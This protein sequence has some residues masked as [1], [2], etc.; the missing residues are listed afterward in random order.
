MTI[1]AFPKSMLL[2]GCGNMAGAMLR[3]WLAG[4][5][6]PGRFVV[7]KPSPDN[8]PG[9][10]AHFGSASAAG[11]PYDTLII[12]V[13]PQMLEP[14][15]GEIRS[16]LAPGALV[17]SIL[18]GV[19]SGSLA[20]HF[21]DARI[22]RVMP[23]LAVA[24]GKSPLG[25]FAKGLSDAEK[26][27]A[28]G[29]LSALGTPYWMAAEDDMHA[30]TAI[31]GCAPA[32]LYRFIDALARAGD[33][34]GIDPAQAETLAK[35][36]AQ[37]AALLAARSEFTPSDLASR[38]ASKGGSTAAGLAVMDEDE[39]ILRLMEKTLRAARDRSVEQ[40]KEAE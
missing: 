16:L 8:L 25:L 17:I 9:G 24:L 5:I 26:S 6:E 13:K 4:G 21:P 28:E 23:N 20:R 29:W 31:A 40:G 3:G 35:E 11:G 22:L 33:Q 15:A 12:G 36:M 34:L 32:Y 30:F 39:A 1:R 10:V 14:L 7:V 19:G 37:G 18:G 27:E 2:F 38:V